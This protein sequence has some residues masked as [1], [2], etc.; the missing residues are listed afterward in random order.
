MRNVKIIE[1]ITELGNFTRGCCH[2]AIFGFS[3]AARNSGL[4]LGL[5]RDE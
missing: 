4:F 2:E 1:K 3:G 5:P